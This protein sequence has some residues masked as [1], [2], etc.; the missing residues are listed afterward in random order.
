MD[1]GDRLHS[2]PTE[3]VNFVHRLAD[4]TLRD[5]LEERRFPRYKLTVEVWVQP[6]NDD[7]EPLGEPF[8]AISRD[9]S[10]G[11]IGIMHTRAVRDKHLWLRLVTLG[12]GTMNV[13]VE[14]LRCRSVGMFYD[15]GA[16][17]VAKLDEA[18]GFEVLKP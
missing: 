11:G 8:T 14:V 4:E 5:H 18:A 3:L 15:I 17:F 6:V 13:V 2:P 10:A 12:G 1:D 7:F 16:K 9:I